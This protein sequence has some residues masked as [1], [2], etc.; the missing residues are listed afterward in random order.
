M[1]TI[2]ILE[3][4]IKKYEDNNKQFKNNSSL[5]IS[6]DAGLSDNINKN[7][8]KSCKSCDIK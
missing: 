7:S 3:K 1:K 5:N 6:L 8:C 2:N 4:K